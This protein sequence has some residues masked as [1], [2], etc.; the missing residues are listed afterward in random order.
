MASV[1]TVWYFELDTGYG[2]Y[3]R[4]DENK[5]PAAIY[6]TLMDLY[7]AAEVEGAICIRRF[8]DKNHYLEVCTF[9][10]KEDPIS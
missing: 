10:G 8:R 2:G 3:I 4:Y 1:K 6:R 9:I 5:E 7:Q